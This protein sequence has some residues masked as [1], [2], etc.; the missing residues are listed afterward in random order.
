MLFVVVSCL[1]C[2]LVANFNSNLLHLT[3]KRAMDDFILMSYWSKSDVS[4]H[5]VYIAVEGLL[6]QGC[7]FDGLR[8]TEVSP[9]D[10]NLTPVPT[11]YL[12]WV[13]KVR[14]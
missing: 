11:S 12:A 1:L 5:P 3:A 13:P 2:L 9:E 8:L 6:V 10:P 4:S 7:Q 14:L